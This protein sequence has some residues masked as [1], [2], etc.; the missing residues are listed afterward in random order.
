MFLVMKRNKKIIKKCFLAFYGQD[1]PVASQGQQ[2]NQSELESSQLMDITNSTATYL[3][4]YTTRTKE[5]VPASKGKKASVKTVTHD[6][7]TLFKIFL[8]N[9]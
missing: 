5:N 1:L 8:W 6:N 2:K 4:T 7:S 3:V 9:S